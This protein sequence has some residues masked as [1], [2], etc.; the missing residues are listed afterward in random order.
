MKTVVNSKEELDAIR[1]YK[2]YK[3][4]KYPKSYPA[5]VEFESYDIE[6]MGDA[7]KTSIVEIPNNVDKE[8][9][10]RGVLTEQEWSYERD[11]FGEK[12]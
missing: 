2:Q 9:F 4:L 12:I 5:I 7:I 8:S 11:T 6:I 10:I 1:P 3:F